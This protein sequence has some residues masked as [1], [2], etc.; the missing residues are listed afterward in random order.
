MGQT[1]SGGLFTCLERR[2]CDLRDQIM[3]LPPGKPEDAEIGAAHIE[4]LS[5]C[6]RRLVHLPAF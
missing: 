5:L 1:L 4:G 6:A 3:A 2:G